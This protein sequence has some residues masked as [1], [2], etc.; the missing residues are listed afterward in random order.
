MEILIQ[1]KGMWSFQIYRPTA[2]LNPLMVSGKNGLDLL[3]QIYNVND[4]W[5]VKIASIE[6]TAIGDGIPDLILTQVAAPGSSGQEIAALDAN[7][8]QIGT[9]VRV[10]S[11]DNPGSDVGLNLLEGY[12]TSGAGG[13]QNTK[14]KFRLFAVELS[15]LGL[16]AGNIGQ[17]AMLELK[18]SSTADPA[19]LAANTASIS[20]DFTYTDTDT[21]GFPDHMDADADGDGCY[22]VTEAGFTDDNFDGQLGPAALTVD[23]DGRVTSGADGYSGTAAIVVDQTQTAAICDTDGD[24]VSPIVDLDDD[25][26]GILDADEHAYNPAEVVAS[27]NYNG[28]SSQPFCYRN[29][30]YHSS[31]RIRLCDIINSDRYDAKLQNG[32]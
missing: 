15:D 12:W 11:S 28:D 24:L 16:N 26:D 7:G 29:S 8:N 3:T 14:R 2:V 5:F 30:N 1:E 32:V 21:D 19:F 13:D 18:L 4:K 23:A 25:N 20:Q 22:D 10:F 6:A 17:V 27:M 31:R 9:G